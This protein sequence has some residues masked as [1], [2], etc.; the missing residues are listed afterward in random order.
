M[1]DFLLVVQDCWLQCISK[2]E[3]DK[4]KLTAVKC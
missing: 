4:G 3:I 1:V 2:L